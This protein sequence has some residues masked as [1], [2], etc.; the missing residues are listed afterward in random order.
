[1]V[2]AKVDDAQVPYARGI[3]S[4]CGAV[5]VALSEYQWAQLVRLPCDRCGKPR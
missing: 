2:A 3:C 5:Q 1:M 4:N